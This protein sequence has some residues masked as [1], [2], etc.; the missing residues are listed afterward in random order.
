MFMLDDMHKL[1]GEYMHK[2]C[3]KQLLLRW[4]VRFQLG[5]LVVQ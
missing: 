1:I 2:K 3:T 5:M 4:L